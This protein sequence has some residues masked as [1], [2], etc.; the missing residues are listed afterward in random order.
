M[1]VGL[2]ISVTDRF[3]RQAGGAHGHGPDDSSA[4]RAPQSGADPELDRPRPSSILT[5]G[6]SSR[7]GGKVSPHRASHRTWSVPRVVARCPISTSS[8]RSRRPP[9]RMRRSSSARSS[10]RCSAG[11]SAAW[12]R[13]TAGSSCSTRPRA[14]ARRRCSSDAALSAA[15]AGCLVRRAAPGPLERHF[16]F[17]VVRALLEAPLREASEERARAAA[18]RGRGVGRHA[19]AGG[20]GPQRRLDDARRPQR[21]VAVL[22]AR[23][24]APARARRR[25]RAV[26]R[27]LV[28]G[29][30][31]LPG[32]AHRRPAAADRRRAPAPTTRAPRRTSS[33]CSAG[34]A[35][36]PSCTPSG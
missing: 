2:P 8:Q 7:A 35:R 1:T 4:P 36:R 27:P 16:P 31:R 13:A 17:G 32:A 26:G 6:G 11:R 20:D 25:R 19:A 9:P 15:A 23:R 33:A 24:R 5:F 12:P 10:S 34:C 18:R 28:A 22:G 3:D 21:A 29:G 30:A 14:W